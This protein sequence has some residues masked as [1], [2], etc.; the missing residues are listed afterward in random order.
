MNENL[1]VHYRKGSSSTHYFQAD[2]PVKSMGEEY[3]TEDI[4]PEIDMS[5][6]TIFD[7][8]PHKGPS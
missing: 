2:L 6:L 7:Y 3:W 4:L 8:F 5:H 1:D